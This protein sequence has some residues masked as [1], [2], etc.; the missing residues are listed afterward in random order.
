M[1]AKINYLF[2]F[3]IISSSES[4]VKSI[5]LLADVTNRFYMEQD[6][7]MCWLQL[8]ERQT[9]DCVMAV[10]K[11]ETNRIQSETAFPQAGLSVGLLERVIAA[12]DNRLVKKKGAS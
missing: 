9:D 10:L 5:N 4:N 2:I 6:T 12:L 1:I 3:T 7:L 11:N 8:P